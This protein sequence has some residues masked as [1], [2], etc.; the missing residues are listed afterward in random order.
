MRPFD[1]LSRR[2]AAPSTVAVVDGFG[3]ADV[4]V[5]ALNVV[6]RRQ[7]LQQIA[8][9]DLLP[10]SA[11]QFARRSLNPGDRCCLIRRDLAASDGRANVTGRSWHCGSTR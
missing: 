2:Q 11:R 5:R 10:G 8:A 1:E 4:L 3:I 7:D 6:A 9:P